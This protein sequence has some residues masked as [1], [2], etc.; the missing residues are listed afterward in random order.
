MPSVHPM[1]TLR[2][3]L[4]GSG[5]SF[6]GYRLAVTGKRSFLYFLFHEFLTIF[7]APFPG[8]C[9]ILLRRLLY[10][11]LFRRFG[12]S[13]SIRENVTLRR[14]Y[15]ISL[16]DHVTLEAGCV[17]DVKGDGAAIV[18]GTGVIIRQGAVLSCPGGEIRIGQGTCVGEESRLGSMLGL[19]LGANCRLGRNSCC[20]G[21][22]HGYA[23]TDV[24]IIDQPVTCRGKSTLG[25]GVILEERATV[26]DGVTIG[27]KATV[28]ADTL[29]T[30]DVSPLTV[31]SGVP[32][33]VVD[34]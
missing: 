1:K 30:R 28:R 21:A 8:R 19:T 3:L 25:N 10:P 18:L 15:A 33:R 34:R 26:L 2:S 20:I 14:P 29:V 17:L 16:G 13:V 6:A 23:R 7:V 31:V 12:R 32:A 4:A 9:G 27:E 11:V 5:N 22:G 24:P